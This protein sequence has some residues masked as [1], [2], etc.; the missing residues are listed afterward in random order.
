ME[1]VANSLS[2]RGKDTTIALLATR[3]RGS[4]TYLVSSSATESPHLRREP[5]RSDERRKLYMFMTSKK[6]WK[7]REEYEEIDVSEAPRKVKVEAFWS[8]RGGKW[9]FMVV[10]MVSA[11]V[12]VFKVK[13]KW[14]WRKEKE[15]RDAPEVLRKVKMEVFWSFYEESEDSWWLWIVMMVSTRVVVFM[16]KKNKWK[17]DH[18]WDH[19]SEESKLPSKPCDH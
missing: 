3:G 18:R 14:K 11:M 2:L 19:R 10:V 8:F 4:T 7:W 1:F 9:R 16:R 13:N 6:K 12:V 15:E 17:T 5:L